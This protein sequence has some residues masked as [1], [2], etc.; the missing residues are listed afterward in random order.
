LIR[1]DL[2]PSS[3]YR[4][5]ISEETYN[6]NVIVNTLIENYKVE[7][8]RNKWDDISE[9]HHT[10]SDWNNPSF[11]E[12][13]TTELLIQYQK[14]ISEFISQIPLCH[15]IKYQYNISNIAVNT[16]YMKSHDHF[17]RKDDSQCMF[18]CVHYIKFDKENHRSTCFKN[19]MIFAQYDDN[20]R[21]VGK[22]LNNTSVI[23]SSYFDTWNIE[24]E[25]NDFV[26]FPSYLKHFVVGKNVSVDNPRIIVVLNI[27]F[28]LK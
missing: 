3:I 24:C 14:I 23:N 9:L 5:K 26:I 18:S 25:E 8:S 27:D 20:I 11:K 13:D 22:L 10:Y 2:F 15:E 6:K 28:L 7:P 21:H 12:I 16:K 4:G 17:Q 19:P 1:Y